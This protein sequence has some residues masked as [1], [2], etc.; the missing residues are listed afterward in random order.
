MDNK[1]NT[2]KVTLFLPSIRYDKRYQK[3]YDFIFHEVRR[4]GFKRSRSE[5]QILKIV[6]GDAII[7]TTGTF[8]GGQ[9]ELDKIVGELEQREITELEN[10]ELVDYDYLF[11]NYSFE[12]VECN[13]ECIND[14]KK[15]FEDY[16]V[17]IDNERKKDENTVILNLTLSSSKE[18]KR[19]FAAQHKFVYDVD[20]PEMLVKCQKEKTMNS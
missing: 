18:L 20:T 11:E 7:S 9:R 13:L 10:Q 2:D 15:T 4:K 1:N 19:F 17:Q 5:P 12:T 6:E 16:G 3:H 8:P 14:V